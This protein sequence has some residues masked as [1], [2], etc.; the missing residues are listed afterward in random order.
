[1]SEVPAVVAFDVVETLFSLEAVRERLVGVGA[2]TNSLE[3]WFARMLRDALAVTAAG[4]Y[5]SFRQAA[6]RARQAARVQLRAGRQ[7]PAAISPLE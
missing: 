6:N 3:L 5:V 1:M 7:A 2:P 4:G